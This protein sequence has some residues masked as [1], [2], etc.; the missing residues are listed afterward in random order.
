[1]DT[2]EKPTSR[3]AR[4]IN[5]RAVELYRR[6]MDSPLPKQFVEIPSPSLCAL[7]ESAGWCCLTL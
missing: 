6:F 1:M 7:H 2:W 4:N 3:K 5:N